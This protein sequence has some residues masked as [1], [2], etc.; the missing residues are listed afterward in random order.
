MAGDDM[1]TQPQLLPISLNGADVVYTPDWVAKD[2]VEWFKPSGRILEP[3]AGDGVFLRYLPED[4]L[5]CEI[6]K[7]RDFFAWHERVDWII[8]NPPY[9]V[10]GQWLRHSIVLSD[11][12]VYLIPIAKPFYGDG[13]LR[14]LWDWGNIKHIRLYGGGSTLNFPIGFAI[15]AIH[16]SKSATCTTYSR[17]TQ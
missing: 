3:S 14:L 10:V 7:G 11:N 5:W 16:F 1:T 4:A 6:E 8:G 13:F 15:G 2:M 12:F 17:W 9:S